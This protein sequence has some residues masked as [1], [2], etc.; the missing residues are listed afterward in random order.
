MTDDP[1]G[2]HTLPGE[3]HPLDAQGAGDARSARGAVR[4]TPPPEIE[5]PPA[6][7][8]AD[9]VAAVERRLRRL[10]TAGA[11]LAAAVLVAAG[12]IGWMAG[13]GGG[14]DWLASPPAGSFLIAFGAMLL[15]LLSSAV[16]GKILRLPAPPDAEDGD[17]LAPADEEDAPGAP[18]GDGGRGGRGGDWRQEP[19]RRRAWWAERL[20]AYSW[21]TGALFAMLGVAAG[22][23]V[24]VA[25]A[26]QAPF[27]GLVIC[28]ASLLGM[29]ARW[30]RRGAFEVALEAEHRPPASRQDGL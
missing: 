28:L 29:A 2:R 13:R 20:R 11:V 12:T 10:G 23:G 3:G 8:V 7:P 5:P 22:L 1:R 16:H 19:Q 30:P 15:V 24:S 21:A 17:R 18:A 27:Y 25:I 14:T 26:G 9:E 6:H 4:G